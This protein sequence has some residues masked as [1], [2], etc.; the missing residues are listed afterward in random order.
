MSIGNF[1]R[2]GVHLPVHPLPGSPA[3]DLESETSPRFLPAFDSPLPARLPACSPACLPGLVSA[4]HSIGRSLHCAATEVLVFHLSCLTTVSVHCTCI[5]HTMSATMAVA[6][7]T[8]LSVRRDVFVSRPLGGVSRLPAQRVK[9][10]RVNAS[11]T[12]K[13]LITPQSDAPVTIKP[14]AS[15]TDDGTD[16]LLMTAAALTPFLLAAEV[17]FVKAS[18]RSF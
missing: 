4:S 13:D 6:A 11:C 15:A 5:A 16:A 7:P 9:C 17:C 12:R 10:L 1:P 2:R 3:L 14:A 18:W 8:S